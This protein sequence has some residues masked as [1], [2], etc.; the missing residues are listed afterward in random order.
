[1]K[2]CRIGCGK[3]PTSYF[4]FLTQAG[5]ENETFVYSN[6]GLKIELCKLDNLI[7]CCKFATLQKTKKQ[8]ITIIFL[9]FATL[10]NF[11]VRG[12]PNVD[13]IVLFNCIF[14]NLFSQVLSAV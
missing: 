2:E 8:K 3:F 7:E 4:I 1:M 6:A 10:F 14:Y 13:C 11:G 12:Y 9:S 5:H